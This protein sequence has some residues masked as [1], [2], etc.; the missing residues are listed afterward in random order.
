MGA[1]LLESLSSTTNHPAR[2]VFIG[3]LTFGHPPHWARLL[4]CNIHY[5]VDRGIFEV[6]CKV[7]HTPW[8]YRVGTE[9]GLSK[10]TGLHQTAYFHGVIR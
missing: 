6:L 3:T 8:R 2:R 7:G 9:Y 4:S 10:T 1:T 5:W